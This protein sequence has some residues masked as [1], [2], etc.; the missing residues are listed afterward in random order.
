MGLCAKLPLP[1]LSIRAPYHVQTLLCKRPLSA[2]TQKTERVCDAHSLRFGRTEST[3]GRYA[4]LE[5]FPIKMYN[6]NVYGNMQKRMQ[7]ND[8]LTY[9]KDEMGL[10]VVECEWS[11]AADLP[12][13][14]A[15]AAS[16][17][18]CACN[19]VDFIAAKV[20]QEVSLPELKRIVSQ[21]STR[22]GMPVVL[23]AQIDARQRKALVSQGIPFVV[24][25]RQAFLPMLGFVTSAK[26]EP[27]PL[28]KVLAPGAQAALVALAANPGLRT[29]GEL[30]RVTGMPSSSVSRAL[31]DLAR[32]G[33]VSKS[34]NGREV[35]ISRI[36]NRNDFV[37]GAIGCLRNPVVRAA[38]T[39]R[40]KQVDLL[41]LAG[42]SALSQRS[43]LAV[44]RIEQRAISRKDFKDLTFEEVQLGELHDEETVQIQVWAYDPLVAG[45]DVVDD[46]SLALTLVGEGDE[47]V[48][49]QLNAL[50]KEE[51]WR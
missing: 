45:G 21:V 2:I 20:D 14:L 48:I 37:K 12:L 16:Y 31:D 39:R 32:R 40:G 33:L 6:S 10:S 4:H 9:L 28:A 13:Y 18:L 27:L 49:G 1:T 25:G 36:G 19:G 34:K 15:K 22:A 43:M 41:P 30:M 17:R 5:T 44:P 47:R 26:R 35:A 46:I 3:D 42:E 29:S 24:P 38:Y 8:A 23:V 7:M 11:G 51:L 50:F